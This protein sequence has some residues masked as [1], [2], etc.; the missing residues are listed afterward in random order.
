M[1]ITRNSTHTLAPM[2][3]ASLAERLGSIAGMGSRVA[4]AAGTP[5]PAPAPQTH[6]HPY[7]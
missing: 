3:T 2:W 1:R 4:V 5:A 7:P 6:P